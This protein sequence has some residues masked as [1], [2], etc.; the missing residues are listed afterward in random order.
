MSRHNCRDPGRW[1]TAVVIGG[2]HSGLA[3]SHCLSGHGIDHVVL[4]RGE[5]ANAWRRE[6]WDSLRLLTPNWQCRLPAYSYDGADPDG[7]MTKAEMAD[8][9]DRYARLAAAPV[10][11]GTR[12]SAVHPDAWGYRVETSAGAWRARAVVIAS[13][14]CSR[15]VVPAVAAALPAGVASVTP[16]QYRNPQALAEGGVLVVGASATG[17]QL[18]EEIQRSGRQVTLAVGEHVRMP[19]RYRGRDIQYWMEA[20]GLLDESYLAVDDIVRARRLPSPQLVGTREGRTLDLNALAAQ[21]VRLAG[22]LAGIRDGTAQFSGSLANVTKLAD[23]K[24]GRLL[25]G[26]DQWIAANGA[27]GG[28]PAPERPAAT[29]IESPPLLAMDLARNGVKT[30]VWATG[31][32]P[33]Y[34][35]LR[36]P[37]LDGR[38]SIRHDGGVTASP[39]LYVMGLPFMRRRSSSF[40]SGAGEDAR[41]ISAHL[42]AWVRGDG[43]CARARV[44]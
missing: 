6:R 29:R 35:W 37:V 10:V 44:A 39:G 11:T 13:G 36:V 33:D 19:R 24:L 3:T 28:L 15:P 41:Q 21:G 34:S 42:A 32:R 27:A 43:D 22:R 30:V 23:L 1:I 5:V 26:I 40:I 18:A 12:V 2:G 9:I 17:L 25:G 20:T 4:E 8:F 16:H 31:F 38:G 14:A 7:F